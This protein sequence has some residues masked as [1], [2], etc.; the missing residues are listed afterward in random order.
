VDARAGVGK[1]ELMLA[2]NDARGKWRL[3]VTDVFSGEK[4]EKSW[5]VR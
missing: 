5:V 1:G 4:V 2:L 3:A